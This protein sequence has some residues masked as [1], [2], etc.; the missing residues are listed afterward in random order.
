MVHTPDALVVATPSW[1]PVGEC[2]D[3]H[4]STWALARVAFVERFRTVPV[5]ITP[6]TLKSTEVDRW[7]LYW[8]TAVT[9]NRRTES[10]FGLGVL[11]A[12]LHV[13]TV[14]TSVQVNCGVGSMPAG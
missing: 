3:S 4:T 7:W 8:S 10:T 12:P 11:K 6:D 9:V 13:E 2:E 14:E 5:K 1:G